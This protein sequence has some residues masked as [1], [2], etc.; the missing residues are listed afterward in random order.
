MK[1]GETVSRPYTSEAEAISAAMKHGQKLG[2][3]GYEAEV[4]MKVMTCRF[5]PKG[6]SRIFPTRSRNAK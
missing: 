6:I 3:D 2:R 5:G 1:A 4:V